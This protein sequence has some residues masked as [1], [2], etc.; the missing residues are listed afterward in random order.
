MILSGSAVQVMGFGLVLCST[1][2]RLIAAYR[3]TTETKNPRLHRRLVSFAKKLS[4]A[5]SHEHDLGVKLDEALV[6]IGPSSRVG[7]L[8][9]GVVAEDS[10]TAFARRHLRLD[11]VKEA[12]K[13][14]GWMRFKREGWNHRATR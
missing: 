1:T 8:V 9:G 5:L 13:L 4:T 10:C 3:S 6:S 7:I 11:R 12:N 2:K 14:R